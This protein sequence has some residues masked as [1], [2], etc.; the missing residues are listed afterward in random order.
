MDRVEVIRYRYAPQ[1]YETLVNDG[2]IV[3]NLKR[4]RWKLLLVPGFVIMQWWQAWGLCRRENVCVIHAHWLIPQGLIAALLHYL[5][6]KTVPFV[7]TSHGADLYA[8]RGHWL[9]TLK[10]WVLKR[11]AAATVVSHAMLGA[12]SRLKVD[13]KK[14]AVLSMGV[15]MESRFTPGRV[16]E[17]LPNELLFV[18]RLVEKKGLRHL[19]DAMPIVLRQRP[20]VFLT[21]AGFGPEE[22]NLREQAR[23]LGIDDVVRFLGAVPQ[24]ALADL[25]R[26]A[27]LMVAPFVQADSGDQEGLGL[28]LV[29]ALACGCPVLAG[30]VPAV[31]DVIDAEWIVDARAPDRLANRIISILSLEGVERA[32]QAEKLRGLLIQRFNWSATAERYADLLDQARG[33]G[34]T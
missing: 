14:I 22:E 33:H 32:A 30:D 8:L 10:R 13:L 2:G 6:G 16:D 5:P 11:S 26:R 21:V 31:R 25:Y 29:E 4:H 28:V 12:F 19:L 9:D 27:T 1:R 7:V 18:G 20:D 15:D 17:R 24:T 34:K 3:A 23:W